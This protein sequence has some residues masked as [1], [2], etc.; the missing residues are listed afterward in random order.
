[1]AAVAIYVAGVAIAVLVVLGF[2]KA[3]PE[4]AND[5]PEVVGIPA[6]LFIAFMTIL[7]CFVAPRFAQVRIAGD[8]EDVDY[9]LSR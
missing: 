8:D 3:F 4:L 9:P 7:P 2:D 1:M 5:H 6:A